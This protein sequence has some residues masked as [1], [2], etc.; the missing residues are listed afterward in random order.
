MPKQIVGC[1]APRCITPSL[2]LGIVLRGKAAFMSAAVSGPCM[3]MLAATGCTVR[4]FLG[5]DPSVMF[6]AARHESATAV[7]ASLLQRARPRFSPS[8]LAARK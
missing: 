8:A 6:R 7:L 2:K 3:R 1:T 5:K 4:F